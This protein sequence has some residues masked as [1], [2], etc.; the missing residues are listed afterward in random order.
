M[1]ELNDDDALD[2]DGEETQPMTREEIDELLE[3][4]DAVTVRYPV[5]GGQ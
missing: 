1:I 2:D 3:M 5:R 4:H